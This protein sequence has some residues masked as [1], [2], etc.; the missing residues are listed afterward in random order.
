MLNDNQGFDVSLCSKIHLK[1]TLKFQGCFTFKNNYVFL[2]QLLTVCIM[3]SLGGNTSYFYF[4]VPGL[5]TAK[6]VLPQNHCQCYK[7]QN[8]A[9]N[10]C[11]IGKRQN[12]ARR[13]IFCAQVSQEIF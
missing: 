3:D 12:I 13:K 7:M 5:H 11:R 4:Q 1:E 10:D 6:D 2:V 8:V 9:Q